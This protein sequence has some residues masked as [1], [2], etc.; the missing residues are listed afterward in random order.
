MFYTSK[1]SIN[2]SIV[3]E[4]LVLDLILWSTSSKTSD[5]FGDGSLELYALPS[6]Y[7]DDEETYIFRVISRDYTCNIKHA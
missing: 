1:F 7:S 6:T 3:F 2:S 4:R 5:A